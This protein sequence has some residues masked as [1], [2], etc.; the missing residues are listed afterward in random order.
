MNIKNLSLSFGVQEVF[1]DVNLNIGNNEKVGVIGVNGAGKT[2]FFKVIMGLIQ[3]DSGRI[4]LENNSRIGLLP[5]VINEEVPSLNINVFD[6]SFKENGEPF[7]IS[8][9]V[10][11]FFKDKNE[12][13]DKNIFEKYGI[14]IIS[15]TYPYA[16]AYISALTGMAGIT[17]IQ[18]PP[19]NVYNLLENMDK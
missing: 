8:I 5:Q 16:R 15:M 19:I 2:T 18:I 1:D 9:T 4:I 7:Y 10:R 12:D 14:N 17:P 13:G 3:P 11:A 6:E